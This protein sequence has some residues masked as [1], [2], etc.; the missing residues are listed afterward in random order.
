MVYEAMQNAT[1]LIQEKQV[2]TFTWWQ[3]QI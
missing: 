3:V 2:V 1:Q